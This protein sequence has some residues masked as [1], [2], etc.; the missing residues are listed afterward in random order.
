MH[1]KH[2]KIIWKQITFKKKLMF[3]ESELYIRVFRKLRFTRRVSNRGHC[4]S[5]V[6]LSFC[7]VKKIRHSAFNARVDR[8]L[9][10]R[11]FTRLGESDRTASRSRLFSSLYLYFAIQVVETVTYE[12]GSCKVIPYRSR[13]LKVTQTLEQIDHCDKPVIKTGPR[14]P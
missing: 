13:S 1:I 4:I 12:A 2:A 11:Q 5:C 14:S 8:Y 9:Q 3:A 7:V 6:S 10:Q